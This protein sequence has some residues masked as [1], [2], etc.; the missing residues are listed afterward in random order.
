MKRQDEILEQIVFCF[1]IDG[2]LCSNTDGDY[3]SATPHP[4]RIERINGLFDG[5]NKIVLFTARG[6]QT[7]LD[8][9]ELT[10]TQLESWG[11]RYHELILGKPFAH[12]YIDDKG[13]SDGDFFSEDFRI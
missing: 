6:T 3:E 8:W 12:Y 9:R 2:T 7:G 1:D 11:V 13:I 4:E 10:V 5:G